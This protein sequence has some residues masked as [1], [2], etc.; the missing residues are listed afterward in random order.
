MLLRR[1]V[2]L[3]LRPGGQGREVSCARSY[4]T[5][6]APVIGSEPDRLYRLLLD[7]VRVYI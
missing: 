2:S 6:G 4:L 7:R 1:T 3:L 5:D